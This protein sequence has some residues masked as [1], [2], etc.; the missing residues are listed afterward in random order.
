MELETLDVRW[1]C[2]AQLDL[3]G[4]SNQLMTTN[5]DIRTQ[6]GTQA[7]ERLSLIEKSIQIFELEKNK[8]PDL[9]PKE[10]QYIRFNDALFLGIDVKYL[11]PP[12][13]QITLTGGY[14]IEQL[15]KLDPEK[16]KLNEEGTTW[17]SGSDVA[18]L[19]G[20]VARI[21]NH[22]NEEEAKRSYPGCRTIVAS[23]LPKVFCQQERR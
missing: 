4:F 22:L 10:L 5:W 2:S 23:G 16:G 12:T 14:S 15:R 21:H 8:Y 1:S 20:L 17:E 6:I 7:I 11:A 13:G 19:L 3:L 18:K 9:Y